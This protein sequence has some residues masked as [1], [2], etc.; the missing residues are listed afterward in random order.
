MDL[1]AAA[2][3][4]PPPC[5]AAHSTRSG[6]NQPHRNEVVRMLDT[7]KTTPYKVQVPNN[8]LGMTSIAATR[9]NRLELI[10]RIRL[11]KI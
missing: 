7:G 10:F 5:D 4:P 11:E 3:P 9:I 6:D 2:S 1:H 8:V